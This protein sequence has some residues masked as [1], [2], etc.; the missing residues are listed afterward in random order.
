[1]ELFLIGA[2]AFAGYSLS[3]PG[4]AI[5]IP[6]HRGAPPRGSEQLHSRKAVVDFE[7]AAT[8]RWWEARNP[9]VTGVVSDS[10]QPFSNAVP[11]FTSARK[12]HTNDEQK[13]HRME[14]LT[15]ADSSWRPKKEVSNLFDPSK[16]DISSSGSAGN[17]PLV[18]DRQPYVSNIQNNVSPT[19]QIRVG[20]GVGLPAN[21]PAGGGFHTEIVRVLPANI[22]EHRLNH[23]PPLPPQ[24]G[25]SI[26]AIR[27]SDVANHKARPP[28]V[29]DLQQNRPLE[30]GGAAVK[31]QAQR[32][33]VQMCH[34]KRDDAHDKIYY[35][36]AG[37]GEHVS[38][39]HL[40]SVQMTRDRDDRMVSLP[41]TNATGA[42]H[43]T[44]GYVKD[45]EACP[46]ATDREHGGHIIAPAGVAAASEAP[47]A[48][49][50]YDV[51]MTTRDVTGMGYGGTA[52]HYVPNGV[53][54]NVTEPTSTLRDVHA[55]KRDYGAGP[56]KAFVN[57][58]MAYCTD[59]QVLREAKRGVHRVENYVPGA[60]RP[61]GR[62]VDDIGRCL[63][64]A[65]RP[66]V[67]SRATP[68]GHAG[69]SVMRAMP[70]HPGQSGRLPNKTTVDNPW[71]MD[72]TLATKQLRTNPL[73]V[74]TTA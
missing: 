13:Q 35:G 25:A 51:G 1:M 5:A 30:Q 21:V 55:Q 19:E 38:A 42:R 4:D 64:V 28:R 50:S 14:I 52:K 9:K 16:Q 34:S 43:G 32:P 48:P 26:I 29:W 62:R 44:G 49:R 11:F 66:D 56:L 23:L 24:H 39:G 17:L 60:N 57:A 37:M 33:D 72:L 47:M 36:V 18:A 54:Q 8:A 3:K 12:Q 58:P 7:R 70:A 67:K 2:I 41:L 74:R 61:Q 22:N 59:K 46:R 10:V 53:V 73:H 69:P 20:K 40:D 65:L 31:A 6:S 15:G 63:S 27:P 71:S 68:V 45:C